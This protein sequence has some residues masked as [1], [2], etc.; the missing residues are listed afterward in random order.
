[1][2]DMLGVHSTTTTMRGFGVC[3][4]LSWSIGHMYILQHLKGM[5]DDTESILLV[6]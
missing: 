1:M 4:P 6:A 3:S 2:R 5:F